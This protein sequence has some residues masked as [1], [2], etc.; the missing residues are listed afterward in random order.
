MKLTIDTKEDS[1]EDIKKVIKMLQ[2]LVGEHSYTNS[3]NIFEDTDSFG[4]GS[5]EES[6]SGSE[7]TNAFVNMFGSASEPKEEP[8]DEPEEEAKEEVPEVVP[9]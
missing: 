4:G 2:H 8:M 7:P 3:P 9:Y 1:H 5:S 6:S